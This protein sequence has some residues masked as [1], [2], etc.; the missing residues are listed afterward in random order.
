MVSKLDDQT[1]EDGEI[2]N[3]QATRQFVLCKYNYDRILV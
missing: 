3:Q 1:I 2:R